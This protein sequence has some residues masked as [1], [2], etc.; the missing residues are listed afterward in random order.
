MR[1]LKTIISLPPGAIP[2]PMIHGLL[3]TIFE[4][5]QWFRPE[6]YGFAA[7]DGRLDPTRIDYDALL[8]QYEE[9]SSITIAARTDRDFLLLSVPRPGVPPH[10]G[11]I[12]WMASEK[13]ASK[14]GWRASHLRQVIEIMRMMRSPLAQA[15]DDDDFERKKWRWVRD[16]ISKKLTFTVR[17]PSEGLPGLLWRNFFGPPFVDLFGERLATLPAEFKQELGDGIVL[18][19]P[20][21]LPTQ[22]GTPEGLARER[23]LIEHLGPECFYDHEHHRK[24]TRLPKLPSPG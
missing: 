19:Q 15:G 13:A 12:N 22:A 4:Q 17:D 5:Y 21:E 23:Q 6:R 16:D 1:H 3:R 11:K 20:Y 18:V 2:S 8:A 9:L 7:L 10:V 14:P 24:P